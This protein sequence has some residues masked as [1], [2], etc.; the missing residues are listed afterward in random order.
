MKIHVFPTLMAAWLAVTPSSPAP[1]FM[2]LGDIK[3]EATETSHRDWSDLDAISVSITRQSSTNAAGAVSTQSRAEVTL[4]KSL[5]RSSPK[6]IE[7]VATGRAVPLLELH[8]TRQLSDG[9]QVVYL[10]YELKNV[11]I[12]S[13]S[14]G[15]SGQGNAAPTDQFSLNF[16][17]IKVTYSLFDRSGRLTED[18]V[19][20]SR[21]DPTKG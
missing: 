14:I 21:F 13:Y 11:L 18:V 12:S 19:T 1:A 16:E 3:G 4:S 15:G 8:L 17:E 9:A 7:L 5:D 2:K 10:K 6:L 20:T